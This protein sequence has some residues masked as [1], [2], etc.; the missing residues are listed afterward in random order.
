MLIHRVRKYSV[1]Q[2]PELVPELVPEQAQVSVL[3]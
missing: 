2:V 3:E 1:L